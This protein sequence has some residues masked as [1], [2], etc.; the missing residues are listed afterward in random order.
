MKN[1]DTC[2]DIFSLSIL[3]TFTFKGPHQS[4]T[5]R[6]LKTTYYL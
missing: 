4:H 1:N 2:E 6:T 3:L 5:I